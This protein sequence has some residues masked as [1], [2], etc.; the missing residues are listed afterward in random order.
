MIVVNT[1][2][3]FPTEIRLKM[4]MYSLLSNANI[5]FYPLNFEFSFIITKIVPF[6]ISI[7]T[8]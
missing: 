3:L 2:M 5:F 4:K 1:Y 7:V 6:Q 8:S